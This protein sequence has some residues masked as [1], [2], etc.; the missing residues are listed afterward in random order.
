MAEMVG[1][2]TFEEHGTQ[3]IPYVVLKYDNG[4]QTK[5]KLLKKVKGRDIFKAKIIVK[6]KE[7]NKK[8]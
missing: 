2:G 4:T 3:K 5:I 1:R 6:R 8:C 7:G